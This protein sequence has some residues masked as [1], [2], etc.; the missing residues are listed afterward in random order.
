MVT[1]IYC[2]HHRRFPRV[3]AVAAYSVPVVGP[4]PVASAILFLLDRFL[5]PCPCHVHEDRL[6]HVVLF[7]LPEARYCYC[8]E[9]RYCYCTHADFDLDPGSLRLRHTSTPVLLLVPPTRHFSCT[10]PCWVDHTGLQ[11][12]PRD[13]SYNKSLPLAQKTTSLADTKSAPSRHTP[14]TRPVS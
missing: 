6:C 3:L 14:Y 12:D 7:Q 1:A 8:H 4:F 13:H 9:D 5:D 2:D 10:L 11:Y